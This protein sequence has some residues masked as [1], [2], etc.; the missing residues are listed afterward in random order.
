[1]TETAAAIAFNPGRGTPLAGSVGFRAPFSQ[2]R[3]ARL[4]P[5]SDLCGPDESG[6]VQVRGPQVFPG[7]V[8]PA[9]NVGTLSPDGWLTTGDVGYMTGDAAAGADRP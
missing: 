9:H 3:I 8:D 6:L 1:M 2:T 7:Y 4:G 5:A